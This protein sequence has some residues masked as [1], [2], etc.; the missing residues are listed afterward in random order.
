MVAKIL[1]YPTIQDKLM[2]KYLKLSFFNNSFI[3]V[4]QS[5]FLLSSLNICELDGGFLGFSLI[6]IIKIKPEIKVIIASTIK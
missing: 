2:H 1:T 4:E 5:L 6:K 3:S